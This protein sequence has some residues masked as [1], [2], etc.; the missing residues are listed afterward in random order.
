[1]AGL[2]TSK[3]LVPQ[4]S[5]NFSLTPGYQNDKYQ[6]YPRG[7]KSGR[8]SSDDHIGVSLILYHPYC[9]VHID[10]GLKF[11]MKCLSTYFH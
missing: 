10:S 3:E 11:S 2:K 5:Y 1:M 7:G 9:L 6:N 4:L 8:L